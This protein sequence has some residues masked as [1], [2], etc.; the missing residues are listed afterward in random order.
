[1]DIN[2]NLII[3]PI[4]CVD[5]ARLEKAKI[6]PC[7]YKIVKFRLH[8]S[9]KYIFININQLF[10]NQG[11]RRLTLSADLESVQKREGRKSIVGLLAELLRQL[12]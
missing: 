1:M 3:H 7:F 2:Q 8:S 4:G 6:T 12:T 5:P 11:M 9:K 10:T